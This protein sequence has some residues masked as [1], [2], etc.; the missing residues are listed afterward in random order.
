M[1]QLVL[2]ILCIGHALASQTELQQAAVNLE[3]REVLRMRNSV[4][5]QELLLE[6][7][8]KT[9][10]SGEAYQKYLVEK[11][12]RHYIALKNSYSLE[13]ESMLDDLQ[14]V[15]AEGGVNEIDHF[16]SEG[17]A[18]MNSYTP[19]Q[20][21][22]AKLVSKMRQLKEGKI[23]KMRGG[24]DQMLYSYQ[25]YIF[26]EIKFTPMESRRTLISVLGTTQVM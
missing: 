22:E 13:P 26:Y 7:P 17:V 23:D 12:L 2:S 19:P 3:M 18:V 14:V 9:A 21:E 25:N 5:I 1:L 10:E 6:A 20:S 4:K 8:D 16:L 15:L 11:V 24:S